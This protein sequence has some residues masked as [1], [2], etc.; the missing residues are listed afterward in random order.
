M[1]NFQAFYLPNVDSGLVGEALTPVNTF[2]VVFNL[3]FNENYEIL[4]DKIYWNDYDKPYD[5]KDITS[6]FISD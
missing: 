4:P 6:I 3:Y 5:F 1:P 2:R